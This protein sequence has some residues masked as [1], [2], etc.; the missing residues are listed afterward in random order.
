MKIKLSKS[1]WEEMGKKAGWTEVSV[2]TSL[3][4]IRQNL[5]HM[6]GKIELVTSGGVKKD[7]IDFESLRSNIVSA[8]EDLD[9]LKKVV[10]ALADLDALKKDKDILYFRKNP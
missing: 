10:F 1:Q 9:A 4:S 6:Q 2:E 3:N 7:E 5:Q 8:L